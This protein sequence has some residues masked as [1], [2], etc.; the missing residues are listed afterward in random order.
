MYKT[1]LKNKMHI[2]EEDEISEREKLIRWWIG[3]KETFFAKR[4]D[5]RG[6]KATG[7]WEVTHP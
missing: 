2:A 7:G 1:R 3:G 6:A 5:E 4:Y